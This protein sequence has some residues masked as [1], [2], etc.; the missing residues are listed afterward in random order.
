MLVTA[1]FDLMR[2][3]DDLSCLMSCFLL[4][5]LHLFTPYSIDLNDKEIGELAG[6]LAAA[7]MHVQAAVQANARANSRANMQ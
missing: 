2:A 3:R 4:I 7:I 1:A 6:T 5:K